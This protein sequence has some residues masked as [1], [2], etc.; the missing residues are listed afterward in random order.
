MGFFVLLVDARTLVP[1]VLSN[2]VKV[3][4]NV[5]FKPTKLVA[6]LPFQE[7]TTFIAACFDSF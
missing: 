5:L 7:L 4:I 2:L 1:Q 3:I 6:A